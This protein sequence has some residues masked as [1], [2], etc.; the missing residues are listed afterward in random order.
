MQDFLC[1]AQQLNTI[2]IKDDLR[3]DDKA[4]Y[5]SKTGQTY[6]PYHYSSA[7]SKII[8]WAIEVFQQKI[9]EMRAKEGL[10]P[11]HV[12]RPSDLP[13]INK[14]THFLATVAKVII[15]L[16]IVGIVF[17]LIALSHSMAR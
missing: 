1:R 14:S 11:M 15:V 10:S 16:V 5:N 4:F 7:Q 8:E 9:N 6:F 13:E 2:G 12:L 3:W 17:G